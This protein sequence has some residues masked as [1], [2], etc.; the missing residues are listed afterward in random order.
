MALS[1]D[2][3]KRKRQLANLAKSN[4]KLAERLAAGDPP[5]P[6]EPAPRR[7]REVVREPAAPA[8]RRERAP[9]RE[10]SPDG[11]APRGSGPSPE[12]EQRGGFLAGLF[13]WL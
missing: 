8:P 1:N 13:D 3:E 4:P 6:R 12:P 5:E 11:R 7:R 9:R 10:A 2:P